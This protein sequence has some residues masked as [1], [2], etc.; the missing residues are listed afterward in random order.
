[1]KKILCVYLVLFAV[2]GA[3]AVSGQKLSDAFIDIK[4]KKLRK[5][6]SQLALLPIVA[7]PAASAPESVLQLISDEVQEILNDEDF[8]L[9]PPQETQKIQAQFKALYPDPE[10]AENQA[11]ISEHT[12][13]ELFYRHAVDGLVSVQVLVV[14]APFRKDKAEWA[15]TTQKVE[16][17]GDGFFGAITGKD[18]EGHIGASAIRIVISDRDGKP[19]YNWMGGVE[20]M[21]Q[22]NGEALEPLPKEDLWQSEKRVRKA[23]NYALKP[24]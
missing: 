2:C 10:T 5:N 20:V 1:M 8:E 16:H 9:L 15:G 22:R 12:I 21:M 24:L 17:R 14:A 11:A 18:Y 23:V 4:E 3:P 7:T 6:Y 19:L 13:R